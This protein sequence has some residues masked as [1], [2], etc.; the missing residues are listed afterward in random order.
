MTPVLYVG[1][2]ECVRACA[3]AWVSVG[4]AFACGAAHGQAYPVKPVRVIVPNA[5]GGL[6][7][8]AARTVFSRLGETLGQQFIVDN[9]PGAGTTIAADLVV[10]SAP[11]GHTIYFI[12][13]TTHAIN[14]T[15]YTKLPYDSVRDFTQIAMVAQT[16]LVMVVH[17][18]LPVRSVKDFIALAKSRPGDIVYGSSG[19]GTIVHLSGETFASMSGTKMV[20]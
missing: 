7:D 17:P 10:K 2:E 18:S 6:A 1:E 19:N 4:F 3:V 13:M 9:R 14:A 20:H 11:D 12:D 8:V 16:P 5:P 15:L